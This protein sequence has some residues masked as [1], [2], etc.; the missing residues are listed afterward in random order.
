MLKEDPT[1]FAA[2]EVNNYHYNCQ[3]LTINNYQKSKQYLSIYMWSRRE[4]QQAATTIDY[5]LL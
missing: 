3:M 5:Y 2:C 4:D 1:K